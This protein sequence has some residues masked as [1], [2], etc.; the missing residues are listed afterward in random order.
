MGLATH[1]VMRPS[2]P[3]KPGQVVTVEPIVEF[4]DKQMHYRVEDTVL[5]TSG[6]PEILSSAIPK[7]LPDVEKLVGSAAK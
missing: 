2:G 3:I 6:E 7:E 5:I 1:D 4:A